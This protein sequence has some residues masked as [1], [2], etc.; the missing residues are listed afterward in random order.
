MIWVMAASLFALVMLGTNLVNYSSAVSKAK[1]YHNNG[2]YAEAYKELVGLKIKDGDLEL[3]YQIVVLAT[4]DSELNAYELFLENDKP[5]EALDSLICAAGRCELNASD[6][7][8]YMCETQ[9]Q[10]L[11]KEV[12]NELNQ[13][14]GMTYE[15]ALEMYRIKGRDNYTLAVHAKIKEL[16]LK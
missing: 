12:S 2:Q 6:A 10:I 8:A 9:M 1:S 3:Y 5:V 14:Y 16:G 4:V 7:I 13:K 15:E 11:K